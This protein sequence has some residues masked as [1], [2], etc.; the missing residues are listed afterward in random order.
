MTSMGVIVSAKGSV[1]AR[2]EGRLAWLMFVNCTLFEL[3]HIQNTGMGIVM[4]PN[5]FD[6]PL[7]AQQQYLRPNEEI[8]DDFPLN[9]SE[10]LT[11]CHRNKGLCITLSQQLAMS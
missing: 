4:Q 3:F 10:V 7:N 8:E 1:P 5:W 9:S 6:I 2:G 11:V